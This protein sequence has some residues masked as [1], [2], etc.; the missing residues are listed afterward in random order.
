MTPL[1]NIVFISM[2]I[3]LCV[4][5][6]DDYRTRRKREKEEELL[7]IQ[8]ENKQ[9]RRSRLLADLITVDDSPGCFPIIT[10]VIGTIMILCMFL[11]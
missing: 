2:F 9:Q 11:I 5:F 1:L 10:L 7:R 6:I 4:I 8:N 3:I